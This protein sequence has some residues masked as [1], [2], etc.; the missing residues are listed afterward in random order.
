MDDV[1]PFSARE[2]KQTY[3]HPHKASSLIWARVVGFGR[4]TIVVVVVGADSSAH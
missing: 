3:E 2:T 1:N 4:A